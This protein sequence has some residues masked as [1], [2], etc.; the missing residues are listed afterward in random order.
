[1]A[2]LTLLGCGMIV[3]ACSEGRTEDNTAGTKVYEEKLE[4]VDVMILRRTDFRKEIISNGKLSAFRKSDLKFRVSGELKELKVKNGDVVKTGQI[5]AVLDQFEYR[6][7][8][9]HAE[10]ALKKA[11]IDL[12]DA[13]LGYGGSKGRENIPEHIYEGAA[14]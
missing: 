12:E 8:L 11:S 7:R 14:I 9:E 2:L 4:E 1:H 13:L 10:M 6:Q 3:I 5:I